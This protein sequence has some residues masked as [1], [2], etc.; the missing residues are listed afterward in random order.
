MNKFVNALGK[1][2]LTVL[3]ILLI[4]YGWAFFEMKILLKSNPELF[5]YV[6][7]Q[8][9]EDD[10]M[11]TLN[12]DDVAIVQKT[13]EFSDGDMIM[14]LNSNDDEYMIRTV[15]GSETNAAYV[16]CDMCDNTREAVQRSTVVGRV[17]GKISYFGKFINFFKQKWFLVTLAIVGFAFVIA[18]QY[19]HEKPK[20]I[21]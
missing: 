7:Y 21:S 5:G 3:I 19:I 6:F 13:S 17:V 10:M 18:S 11:P 4:G 16:T 12:K 20:K 14:F 2:F 1:S 9:T 15:V 8:Y